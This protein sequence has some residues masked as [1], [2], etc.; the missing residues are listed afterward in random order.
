MTVAVVAV[1]SGMA[2]AHADSAPRPTGTDAGPG[3][4]PLFADADM[5]R[6]R[7][8]NR[9][10]SDE[11]VRRQT[12]PA[13]PRIDRLPQPAKHTPVDI[14]ALAR[15]FDAQVQ[16]ASL[17][18]ATGPSLMV[19]ISFAM[20]EAALARLVEQASRTQ[21]TLVLRGL[22]DGSLVRTASR[23]HSLIGTRK[24]AVQIDPQAFDRYAVA[25]IP[26]F[27]L[28]REDASAM[29]CATGLC[30]PAEGYVIVAGDVTLDYALRH[31]RRTAPHFAK[32]ASS[33]LLR[34][35]R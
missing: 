35:E 21:A 25:Q 30:P 6:A 16:S 17:R 29:P 3:G 34:L 4:H 2:P 9:T 24:T 28:T 13:A 20:P 18:R 33:L 26:S 8:R 22:V 32:D 7:A 31:I 5:R 14:E 27:V 19:F 12:A 23:V 10:P 11:E 15:G 1:L